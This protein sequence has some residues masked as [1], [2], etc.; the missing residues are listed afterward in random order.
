MTKV[1]TEHS[2]TFPFSRVAQTGE[3]FMAV[4]SQFEMS[5]VQVSDVMAMDA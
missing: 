3:G 1:E 5:Q 2:K 4:E